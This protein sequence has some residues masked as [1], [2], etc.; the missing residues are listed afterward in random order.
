MAEQGKGKVETE[1]ERKARIRK[2]ARDAAVAAFE[3]LGADP[4]GATVTIVADG[5]QVTLPLNPMVFSSGSLG[6]HQ[7][8]AVEATDGRRYQL[9]M[10]LT[11]IG[12][13][14]LFP[15]PEKP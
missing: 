15:V 3:Q 5:A 14:G 10:T 4:Q 11:A 2:A 6:F 13:K 7:S 9:G 8:S 12:T 1:A